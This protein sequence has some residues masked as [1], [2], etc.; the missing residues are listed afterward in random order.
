MRKGYIAA[1]KKIVDKESKEVVIERVHWRELGQVLQTSMPNAVLTGVQA[2]QSESTYYAID[3]GEMLVDDIKTA[4]L[5]L[6]RHFLTA[7]TEHRADFYLVVPYNHSAF[8]Y[9]NDEE[10]MRRANRIQIYLDLM[11]SDDQR[12]NELGAIYR[13]KAIGY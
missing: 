4:E 11:S 7:P 13:E 1:K 3:I 8:M 5:I 2:A 9:P 12:A 6:R 10:Q